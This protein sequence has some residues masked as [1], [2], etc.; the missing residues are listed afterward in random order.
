MPQMYVG[1]KCP[2]CGVALD[3]ENLSMPFTTAVDAPTPR[4]EMAPFFRFGIWLLPVEKRHPETERITLDP[5]ILTVLERECG[6]TFRSL[7]TPLRLVREGLPTTT[8]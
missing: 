8:E 4:V 1:P 5:Q 3:L 7:G 2:H 6:V